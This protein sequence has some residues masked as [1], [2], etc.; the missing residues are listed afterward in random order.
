MTIIEL[1]GYVSTT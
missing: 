1:N